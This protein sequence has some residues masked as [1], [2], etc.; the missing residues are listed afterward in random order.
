MNVP[1]H[2]MRFFCS[3]HQSYVDNTLIQIKKHYGDNLSGLAIYGSYARLDNRANS[4]LDLLI[5][6]R[7]TVGRS[8]RISDFITHIEMPLEPEAQKLFENDFILCELSPYILT[9]NEAMHFQTIYSDFVDSHI[10]VY[11][12]DKYLERIIAAT[13]QL[14]LDV[15]ATKL[16]RNNSWEWQFT[17]YLGGVTL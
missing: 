11:D 5:I 17:R 13:K 10:L 4:D 6:L 9:C 12:P 16:R 15:N 14:L 3:A 2:Q 7:S 8:Q 1:S